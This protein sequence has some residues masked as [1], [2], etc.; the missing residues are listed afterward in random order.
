MKIDQDQTIRK[1][2]RIK[3]YPES[4][5]ASTSGDRLADANLLDRLLYLREIGELDKSNFIEPD[6]VKGLHDPFLLKDMD[7]TVSRIIEAVLNNQVILVYSD[8]DAD[9]IPGS[10][11]IHDF[12]KKIKYENVLYFRPDRH[13]E[14]FGLHAHIL[15]DKKYNDISLIITIDCGIADVESIKKINKYF[16]SNSKKVDIIITDHHLP[17]PT[18]PDVYAIVNPKQ[19]LC[20]YPEKMLC[21]SGVIFKVVCALVETL[22][23]KHDEYLKNKSIDFGLGYEKWLL[24]LV[25]LATLSDMVP[26]RGENRLLAYYGLIVMQKT[27]R[28]G[29]IALAKVNKL[30]LKSINEDDIVFTFSPR[31]N[32]A[33]RLASA[34]LAFDLLTTDSFDKAIEIAKTLQ[35]INTKRKTLVATITK[36]AHTE[37]KNRNLDNSH[38]IA[39]GNPDWK[40]PVLGLVATSLVKTYKRPVFV[41]GRSED[42]QYK[43]S[44]RGV[45]GI[46]ITKIMHEMED[47]IFINR[48]GHAEAGGFTVAP[49]KI[50]EFENTINTAYKNIYLNHSDLSEGSLENYVDIYGVN[51]IVE[52]IHEIDSEINLSAFN[53]S[54]LNILDKLAPYG[55]ANPKPLFIIKNCY[56]TNIKMFGKE[57]DH[58]EITITD[59]SL[60]LSRGISCIQFFHEKNF[61]DK[62][63]SEQLIVK[64][65]SIIGHMEKNQFGGYKNIR[66][67]LVDILEE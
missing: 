37:I 2:Y 44:T 64:R 9:G 19:E 51:N 31:I 59:D 7:K 30:D 61:A 60:G 55:M 3:E 66:L 33:S 27:K 4:V 13:N 41:W 47:E 8:F 57:N 46:D 25:G 67:R 34:D 36:Q 53:L 28:P 5:I 24:D 49:D 26:L 20:L 40:P 54:T 42:G 48:G 6:Y 29:F 35:S 43:G 10:A 21:G 17:G 16:S 39:I 14:G 22:K 50:F 63:N 38:V 18:I 62:Y 11:V 65:F 58:L 12:F 32:V 52:D 23:F 15:E 45:K 1:N 56:I